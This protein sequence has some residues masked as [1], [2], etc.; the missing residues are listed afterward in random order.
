MSADLVKQPDDDPVPVDPPE[1]PI[2][3]YG[4]V[5]AAKTSNRRPIVPAWA[6]NRG[7][8]SAL[9]AWIARYGAH[10]VAY[11]A[12]RSPIYAAR[13]VWRAPMGVL[14]ALVTTLGWIFDREAATLRLAA[15]ARVDTGDYLRLSKQRN[16]RVRRRSIIVA[17]CATVLVT[18]VVL[19]LAVGPP[20]LVL[21]AVLLAVG[22]LGKL[23][24]PDDRR[25]TDPA[26]VNASAPPRL[27]AD[28]VTRALT[29]LG[30]AAMNVKGATVAFP[31][32]ITRDGPGWRADVDLPF[33]VTVAD[34]VE[35]RDRLAS[36]LRR[37]L[38]A[39]WPEATAAEH[40]G[41]LILWVGDQPLNA[42][43]PAVWPLAKVGKVDL[44]GGMFPFGV[45]QRQR[46]VMVSLAETNA[47]VGSLPGGGKTSA[48]RVLALAAALD[49]L[50]EIRISEH[51]GS[52]DLSALEKV[53]H[54]Y[55]S[56][57]D[58]AAI[59]A[60]VASLRE[61]Y[62][63]LARRAEVIRKLPRDLVPD[64]KVTPEL[65]GRRSLRL[66]PLVVVVDEAQEV[67]GHSEYGEEAGKL[68]EAI[69]KRGR[70]LAVILIIATQRPDARSLPTGVSANVGVRFCLRVM[71][72]TEND[73]VLGTSSYKNGVRATTFT[74]RDRGIGY[75]VGVG[76]DPLVVRTYYIDRVQADTIAER[77]RVARERAGTLTGHCLGEEVPLT[78]A[79]SLLDDLRTIFATATVE[80][81]WS[82]DVCVRLA[83]LR[84]ELYGR[85]TPEALAAA[86]KPHGITTAQVWGRTPEG[87]GANRRGLSR[88]AVMTDRPE[89]TR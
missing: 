37:P 3:I 88:Q 48:V 56:G 62:A 46:P 47:L 77:A 35:R 29:S 43:K 18:V 19:V 27:T 70:A 2:T 1:P 59:E 14:V 49:P 50:A 11:H 6:R 10:I 32:P 25:I 68:C 52:G 12:T 51:K 4:T 41:R 55:V 63:E 26:T 20:W 36:G 23:G 34:V 5:L 86:L 60:T 64:S 67:F 40:A 28:V 33:G 38:S 7:E 45:D 84:P 71:G 74:P 57:V 24:T 82:E 53:A 22:V 72:Q 85:L 8:A 79:A 80:K 15:V 30:I 66:H 16:D 54:R 87:V 89:I 78:P 81:M 83:E 17:A 69:I 76:D 42:M 39:V 58:D 21:A 31:A 73:M 9:A 61:V 13:L 44:L 65:A 75:L